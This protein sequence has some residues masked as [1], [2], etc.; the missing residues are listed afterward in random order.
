M[1]SAPFEP[2][3]MD[4]YNQ[5]AQKDQDTSGGYSMIQVITGYC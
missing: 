5:S 3:A 1:Y 4:N 2:I